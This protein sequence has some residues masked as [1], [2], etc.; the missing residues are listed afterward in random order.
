ME[1]FL[2]KLYSYEYFST[3]LIIAI[4][5]LIILFFVILF[6]G[7]KDKKER[8]I[9]ATKKLMKINEET[10]NDE[11]GIEKPKTEQEVLENDTIIVPSISEVVKE[12]PVQEFVPEATL[13][14]NETISEPDKVDAPFV[15]ISPVINESVFDENP[16]EG[17]PAEENNNPNME[18]ENETNSMESND[19]EKA[20]E[21]VDYT[22]IFNADTFHGFKEEPKEEKAEVP[23]NDFEPVLFNEEEKPLVV[24]EFKYEEPVKPTEVSVPEFNYDNVIRNVE[25]SIKDEHHE[26]KKGPEIFSSVYVPEEKVELQ[27]SEEEEIELPSLKKDAMEK[28]KIPDVNNFNFEDISGETYNIK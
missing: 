15:P 13:P 25:S 22:P 27:K 12:E 5:V 16:V 24:D 7:N 26:A 8:E 9:E 23:I 21:F 2:T 4:V 3:Y 17:N 19:F 1:E 10:L 6:F 18:S 28:K 20:Y 11:L 14:N